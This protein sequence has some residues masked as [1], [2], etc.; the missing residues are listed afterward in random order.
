[1]VTDVTKGSEVSQ[2]HEKITDKAS[3]DAPAVPEALD[4]PLRNL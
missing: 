3:V 2:M 1:M 4:D